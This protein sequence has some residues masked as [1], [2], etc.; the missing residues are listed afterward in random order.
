MPNQQAARLPGNLGAASR[1]NETSADAQMDLAAQDAGNHKRSDAA[2]Q[3][4][5][6]IPSN[7]LGASDGHN[8][9]F[10]QYEFEV[11]PP[12]AEN[13]QRQA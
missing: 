3:S 8:I 6:D 2:D 4:A 9:S 10:D 5:P 13:R 7:A 11:P 12:V 1:T